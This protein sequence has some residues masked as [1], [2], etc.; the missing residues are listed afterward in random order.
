MKNARTPVPYTRKGRGSGEVASNSQPVV[1]FQRPS[2]EKGCKKVFSHPFSH[3]NF[4]K[5][6]LQPSSFPT[7]AFAVPHFPYAQ[8]ITTKG[9]YNKNFSF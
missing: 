5:Q 7:H 6:F 3:P 2:L 4:F 8:G 9:D 1:S